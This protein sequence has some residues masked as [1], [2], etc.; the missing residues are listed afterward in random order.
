MGCIGM[1]MGVV[2]SCKFGMFWGDVGLD[3]RMGLVASVLI[4]VGNARI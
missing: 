2:L 3:R 1:I 4:V